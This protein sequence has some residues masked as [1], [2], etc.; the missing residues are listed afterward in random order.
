MDLS[1][2]HPTRRKMIRTLLLGA[3][4]S[5]AVLAVLSRASANSRVPVIPGF[6]KIVGDV[7]LNGAPA[8]V[9]QLVQ[10]GDVC[11]TGVNSECV[12]IIGEHV[13]LL[14]DR[15]EVEFYPEDIEPQPTNFVSGTIKLVAGAMMGVF[16]D[17]NTVITTPMATIGIRGTG[18]YTEA[19]PQRNYVCLCYGRA[20]VRANASA[21]VGEDLSTTHHD[22]PRTFYAPPGEGA[23]EQGG[24]FMEAAQMVN[25]RDEELIMLE[26]LVGRIPLFGPDPIKMPDQT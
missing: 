22:A 2:F 4:L 11:T 18:V 19:E 7:R 12:I 8:Q 17:T 10:A 3:G 26:A 5:P 14:R 21:A 6:Q 25:H 13:F 9:G 20:H 24:P 15:A 23:D 1:R 16:G